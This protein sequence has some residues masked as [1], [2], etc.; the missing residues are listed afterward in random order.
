MEGAADIPIIGDFVRD[1]FGVAHSPAPSTADYDVP[2]TFGGGTGTA[3]AGYMIMCNT[4]RLTISMML[5][6]AFCDLVA[7]ISGGSV[8]SFLGGMCP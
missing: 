4:E 3:S 1:F 7:S 2:N 8:P 5:K 6:R